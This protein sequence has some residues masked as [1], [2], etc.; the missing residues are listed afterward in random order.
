MHVEVGLMFLKSS[1]VSAGPHKKFWVRLSVV[2]S[3][4]ARGLQGSRMAKPR[5]WIG[6]CLAQTLI[7]PAPL[8]LYPPGFVTLSVDINVPL[9]AT[10][11]P[12]KI[13]QR[14]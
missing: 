4:V 7:S 11:D 9:E 10:I 14:F 3:R 12:V 8:Q 5:D 13:M 6:A 1:A 2:C